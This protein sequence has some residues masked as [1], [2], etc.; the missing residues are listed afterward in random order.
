MNFITR[1]FIV[2]IERSDDSPPNSVQRYAPA[3]YWRVGTEKGSEA[4]K[5]EGVEKCLKNTTRTRQSGAC[6][7]GWLF[8]KRPALLRS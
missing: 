7:A 8:L 5:R 2:I 4:G 6:F 1:A 3:G